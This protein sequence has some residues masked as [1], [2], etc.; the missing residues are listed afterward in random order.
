MIRKLCALAGVITLLALSTA[1]AVDGTSR[2]WVYFRDKNLTPGERQSALVRAEQTLTARARA[3]RE[4]N[5]VAL[6]EDSDLP[7]SESYVDQVRASGVHVRTV[8]PWFNAV[9]VEATPDQMQMIGRMPC[10]QRVDE[11]HLVKAGSDPQSA[12]GPR[13]QLDDPNYGPSRMQYALSHIPELHHR[14]LSGRGVMICFL[15]SG[16]ELYHHAFDSMNVV[17]KYDF[18]HGDTT[19]QDI[20]GQDSAGQSSH[21]T[22][23]LSV[24]GGY[25]E[26]SLVGPAYHSDYL[27]AKTEWVPTETQVEEDNY[28]AALHWADSIGTDITS[29]SLGYIGPDSSNLWY[30]FAQLDGHTATT[31]RGLEFAASHGILCVT[32]AG[33]ERNDFWFPNWHHIVTPADADSI[34][35]VGA[36]DSFGVITGFS[37]PGPTGDGRIKPDISAMG[38]DVYWAQAYTLDNYG[39]AAGTSLSTPIVAG[40]AALVMEAHPTWT[41]QQVRHAMMSTASDAQDPNNDYGWGLMDAE[42]AADFVI[43]DVPGGRQAVPRSTVLLS[44]FPNPVNGV[45][46]FTLTLPS[47]GT[48]KLVLYDVLGREAYAWQQSKW[49][50][51]EQRVALNTAGFVSGI[52]FARFEG[53]AGSAIQKMVILK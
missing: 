19:V 26:G 20:A 40:A 31:T 28:V 29:S 14:G 9:S 51:G 35:A 18:I 23:T 39:Y 44:A 12:R 33:N 8:S 50:A 21:G 46:T 13:R 16:F 38:L 45:A 30:T 22:G 47:D 25:R 11:F 36:V 1:Y 3:R 5:H 7:V 42:A 17:A 53:S 4:K 15:D 37:S 34:L 32:A 2:Y 24:C 41:A 48:G 49:S 27:C 43:D 6:A 52:Y 10:V